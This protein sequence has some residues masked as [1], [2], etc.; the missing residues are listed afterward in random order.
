MFDQLFERSHALA[1]HLSGALVD[2][3]RRYLVHCAEQAMAKSTLRRIADLLMAAEE[4]LKLSERPFAT[5]AIQEIEEAGSRWST[6]KSLPPIRLHPRVSRQ[7]FI[8]TAVGWLTAINR[9][10]IP[11]K[12]VRVYDQMIVEFA[13]F[14]QKERGGFGQTSSAAKRGLKRVGLL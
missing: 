5:I 6:R 10:Q 9:L 13:E 12:P 7:R 8:H 1:R 3:R 2:E 14:M 11:S 4:Y